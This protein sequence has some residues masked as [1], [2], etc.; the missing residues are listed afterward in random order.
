[1]ALGKGGITWLGPRPPIG[2]G[3]AR[4]PGVSAAAGMGSPGVKGVASTAVVCPSVRITSRAGIASA[5][6]VATILG[7]VSGCSGRRVAP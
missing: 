7:R 6:S 1:M 3:D 5:S 4:R 2:A